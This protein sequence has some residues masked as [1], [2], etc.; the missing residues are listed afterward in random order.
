[1]FVLVSLCTFSVL[2]WLPTFLIDKLNYDRTTAALLAGL[3]VA[4]MIPFNLLGGLSVTR[5]VAMSTT[6]QALMFTDDPSNRPESDPI[7]L[8]TELA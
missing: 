1:M 7:S 6:S 4:G 5:R 2:A 8:D 3:Y